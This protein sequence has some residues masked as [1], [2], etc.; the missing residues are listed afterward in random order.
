M[1]NVARSCIGYREHTTRLK[2]AAGTQAAIYANFSLP[3]A[4][5]LMIP[6]TAKEYQSAIAMNPVDFSHM[7][8]HLL[9]HCDHSQ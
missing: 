2:P 8:K 9:A 6:I 5:P 1:E 4:A 7:D 3:V